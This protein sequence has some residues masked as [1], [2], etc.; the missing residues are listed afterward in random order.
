MFLSDHFIITFSRSD[1]RSFTSC[2]DL[3]AIGIRVSLPNYGAQNAIDMRI[4]RVSRLAP[5]I[6]TS[7]SNKL[8]RSRAVESRMLLNQLH[9]LFDDVFI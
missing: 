2:S 7:S 1:R 4:S 5:L 3:I 6:L 9:V 8:G